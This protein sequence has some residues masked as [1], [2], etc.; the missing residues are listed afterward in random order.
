[1]TRGKGFKID[2]ADTNTI[3]KSTGKG[4]QNSAIKLRSINQFDLS[5]FFIIVH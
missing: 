1:M 3:N 2:R 5:S 4:M